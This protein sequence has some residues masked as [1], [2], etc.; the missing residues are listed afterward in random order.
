MRIAIVDHIISASNIYQDCVLEI[1]VGFPIDIIP[2]VMGDIY[3]ITDINWL[4]RFGA[5]VD[6]EKQL[7]T[8]R[9]ICNYLQML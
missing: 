3:V 7:V 5:L 6:Y 9:S 1:C 4:S 2:I 8:V